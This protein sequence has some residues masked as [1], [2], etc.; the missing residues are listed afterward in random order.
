MNERKPSPRG[1]QPKKADFPVARGV[2]P[3]PRPVRRAVPPPLPKAPPRRRDTAVESEFAFGDGRRVIVRRPARRRPQRHRGLIIALQAVAVV[4]LAGFCMAAGWWLFHGRTPPPAESPPLAKAEP[5]KPGKAVVVE[6][7]KPVEKPAAPVAPL[8]PVKAPAKPV[9]KPVE[10]PAAPAP[11]PPMPV[12]PAPAPPPKPA[13]TTL[14]FQRDIL[15]ILKA[16]CAG[17]HGDGR[18]KLKGGLDVRS[19]RALEKGGDGG[20]AIDRQNPEVSPLWDTVATGQ[21]PPGKSTKLT[22]SEK[23]KL[24]DW[25]VGGGK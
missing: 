1:P 11:P 6:P 5:A 7:A 2:A 3:P 9:E 24:H 12:T 25:I 15:P 19:V 16:K 23:K 8:P 18:G 22:E 20:P 13:T 17:C 14:T 4:M 21:M 10:K